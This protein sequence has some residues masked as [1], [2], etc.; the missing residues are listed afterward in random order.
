MSWLREMMNDERMKAAI[1]R[2]KSEG[3]PMPAALFDFDD[4]LEAVQ[5]IEESIKAKGESERSEGTK[6]IREIGMDPKRSFLD[7]MPFTNMAMS[8]WKTDIV[9]PAILR[10]SVF[11][12]VSSHAEGVLQLWCRGL[13]GSWLLGKP[14]K[15]KGDRAVQA[16]LRY[17]KEE[18]NLHLGDFE[19]WDEYI[20]FNV[21]WDVRNVIVHEA[22]VV[23]KSLDVSSVEDFVQIDDSQLLMPHERV[24]HLLPGACEDAARTARKLLDRIGAAYLEMAE[25]GLSQQ[26][27]E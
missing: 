8:F 1:E 3:L 25:A 10:R 27:S 7:E 11:V 15:N 12:A 4:V 9:F 5:L 21:Y 13:Q 26:Q 17:L 2:L 14:K 16:Y 23:T 24:V 20:K 18:A 6:Q 19:S 22:G